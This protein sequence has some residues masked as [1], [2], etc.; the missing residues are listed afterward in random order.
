[1]FEFSIEINLVNSKD[2]KRLGKKFKSSR[3]KEE[4]AF[5]NIYTFYFSGSYRVLV[6]C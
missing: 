3:Q 2:M 6:E 5:D 1:M 4:I